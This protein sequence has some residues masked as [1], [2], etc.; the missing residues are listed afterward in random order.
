MTEFP[1]SVNMSLGALLMREQVDNLL[2][3]YT[4]GLPCEGKITWQMLSAA[5]AGI[6]R[7]GF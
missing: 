7:N 3:E 6:L 4:E 2:L 5:V 1:P